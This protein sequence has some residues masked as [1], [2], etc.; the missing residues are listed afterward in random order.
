M[1][2]SPSRVDC[3]LPGML[4]LLPS[5]INVDS[6]HDI[7]SVAQAQFDNSDLDARQCLR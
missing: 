4:C 5:R 7:S 3:I 6:N 2:S 1:V